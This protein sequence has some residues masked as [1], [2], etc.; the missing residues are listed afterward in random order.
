MTPESLVKDI[1]SVLAPRSKPLFK[2]DKARSL[3]LSDHGRSPHKGLEFAEDLFGCGAFGSCPAIPVSP[4]IKLF[5]G[6]SVNVEP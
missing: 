1:D 6:L 4:L 2:Q 5:R 3:A